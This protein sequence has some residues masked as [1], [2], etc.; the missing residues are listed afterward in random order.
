MDGAVASSEDLAEVF[1]FFIDSGV[2]SN[3]DFQAS[4]PLI[5]PQ[6]TV[7]FQS[8]DE[9]YEEVGT[10]GFLNSTFIIFP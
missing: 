4:I 9:F 2:E 7:L 8:D 10:P 3:L 1:G 5:Y 6:T